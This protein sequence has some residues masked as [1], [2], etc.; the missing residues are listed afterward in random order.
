LGK[1][2]AVLR[3]QGPIA[4]TLVSPAFST[5]QN[6]PVA[7]KPHRNAMTRRRSAAAIGFE[8][9]PLSSIASCVLIMSATKSCSSR[10]SRIIPGGAVVTCLGEGLIVRCH[11]LLNNNPPMIMASNPVVVIEPVRAYPA[12]LLFPTRFKRM[13]KIQT[14][15]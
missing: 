9:M 2:V 15:V 7:A 11:W 1:Q 8:S 12:T 6:P 4:S 13:I 3:D 14:P 10:T 5:P